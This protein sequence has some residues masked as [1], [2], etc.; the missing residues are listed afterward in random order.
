MVAWVIDSTYSRPEY[1]QTDGVQSAPRKTERYAVPLRQ[2]L[3]M[4]HSLE[5]LSA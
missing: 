5:S 3:G 2:V 4:W 1:T